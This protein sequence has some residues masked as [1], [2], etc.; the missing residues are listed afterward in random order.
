MT[1]LDVEALR[2][3]TRGELSRDEALAARRHLA[4]CD[5]C[6]ARLDQV[7]VHREPERRLGRYVLLDEL[8]RGG[9]GRVMRAFDPQLDRF[10][11]IKRGLGGAGDD[12]ARERLLR[13]AQAMARLVAPH[14]VAVFDAGVDEAGEVYLVMEYV[15]G[16]T[17]AQW[18]DEAPRT[19]REVLQ[20]FR[21]AGEGLAAAHAAGLVHRDFKPSNVLVQDGVAK[22]TDFGL[23]LAAA[24]QT[25]KAAPT[26][27]PVVDRASRVS[28]RVTEAGVNA[29]TPAYMAP[30]QFVGR[31]DARSDQ[32]A[33]ARSLEEALDG[34]R[35]PG[36]VRAALARALSPDAS[37]RYPS[38]SDFLAALAPERRAR[39]DALLAAGVALALVAGGAWG[40]LQGP[41]V[42]CTGAAAAMDGV[43]SD[44]TQ[45]GLRAALSDRPEAVQRRTLG[46]LQQ[47]VNGWRERRVVSCEAQVRDER[48]ELL[49]RACLERRLDF[50]RT[51]VGQ[52]TAGKVSGEQLAAVAGELPAVG[53]GDAELVDTGVADESVEESERLAGARTAVAEV[54]ALV[55]LEDFQSATPRARAAL[56]AARA[57][58]EPSLIA[59]AA[60]LLGQCLALSQ[61]SEARSLFA[62]A[63]RLSAGLTRP[64][65]ATA[66]LAARAALELLDS[67]ATEPAAFEALRPLVEAA[68]E[69]SGVQAEA[70][71]SYLAFQGRALMKR[72][73]ASE[74]VPL[75]ERAWKA[76]RE[77]SGDEAERTRAIRT[78]YAA[79]L[80]DAGRAEEAISHRRALLEFAE[81]LTG[82]DSYLS[83]LAMGDLGTAELLARRYD[84]A[85][86]HLEAAAARLGKRG[87]LPVY[88]LDNLASLAEALGDF[89]R[90]GPLRERV[91]ALPQDDD[92]LA[93]QRGLASRVSLE[94]GRAAEA[95]AQAR[96]AI[97]H[98]EVQDPQHPHLLV[99]LTTLGR[100]SRG[101]P[102]VA[103]LHRA[104]ALPEAAHQPEYRGDA[105]LAMAMRSA[106]RAR[107][108]WLDR[109]RASYAEAN[110]PFRGRLV[111]TEAAVS[112]PR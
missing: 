112:S 53:C 17:L 106:G 47:W 8:G 84:E 19:W 15:R 92:S 68:L 77:L 55:L 109:A 36:W 2:R 72:G 81:R 48:L 7:E 5:A 28:A 1:C 93:F 40:V 43:W 37:A 96:L 79:A 56:E 29:G 30:E 97:A 66:V 103:L 64:A 41:R 104:L 18:L 45:A 31:Y 62:E 9:M 46:A 52:V 60:L 95:E 50:F 65:P 76:R 35:A 107:E 25:E 110:I 13:E 34:R 88:L 27:A 105:E 108:V 89:A 74:A 4:G 21:Q 12:A 102:G 78:D 42:D 16:P 11:A 54:E 14:V 100:I 32:Y 98:L 44:V 61:P 39:R 67:H 51:V 71:T 69:R 91:L 87:E 49:R 58:G 22:V 10:V 6:S 20:L 24:A 86:P 94:L 75:L 83:G 26:P 101:A 33:F 80:E 63:A 111:A 57:T 99:P 90:A 3:L 85:G 82:P 70:Q 38:M 59:A 23:A 73:R